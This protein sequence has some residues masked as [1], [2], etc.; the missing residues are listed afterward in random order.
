MKADRE[1]ERLLNEARRIRDNVQGIFD[2]VAHWNAHVRQP[3]EEP[4]DPDPTGEMR[5]ILDGIDR[6]LANDKGAGP[7]A[8]IFVKH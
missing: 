6:M 4:I 8:P 5:M 2:D 3:D 1:R 7:L